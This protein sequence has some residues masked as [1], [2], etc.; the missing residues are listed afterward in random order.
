MKSLKSGRRFVAVFAT[1]AT[2]IFL[3]ACGGGGSSSTGGS[4]LTAGSATLSGN[5]NSGIAWH[6][7]AGDAQQL[8]ISLLEL[9]IAEAQ[10]SGVGGVEVELLFNGAV[11]GVQTT[12]ASGDF[13][14]NGLQP[15]QYTVRLSQGGQQVGVSPVIQLE[16]N[17]RTKLDMKLNGRLMEVEIEA[18]KG[19]I[20]GEVEREDDDDDDDDHAEYHRDDHD[21]DDDDHHDDDDDDDE[22]DEDEDDDDEEDNRDEDDDDCDDDDD[23]E[24]RA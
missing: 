15:G 10:A 19:T 9:A 2:V 14:F 3:G 17:T 13:I 8:L 20:S 7:S 1:L 16:A 12:T 24:C 11:I 5:V 23:E 6:E 22:E 21:D 4:S 18:E